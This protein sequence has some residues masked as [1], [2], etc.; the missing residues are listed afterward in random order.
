MRQFCNEPLPVVLA[1]SFAVE[2]SVEHRLDADL[3][4]YANHLHRKRPGTFG[5]CVR[6]V[7]QTQLFRRSRRSQLRRCC[8]LYACY[9]LADHRVDRLTN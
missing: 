2:R 5:D 6:R 9:G 7:R 3:Q 1:S 4:E 8:L